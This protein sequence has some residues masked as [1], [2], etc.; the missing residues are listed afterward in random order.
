MGEVKIKKRADTKKKKKK[1]KKTLVLPAVVN[2]AK[3][4][5]SCSSNNIGMK[6]VQIQTPYV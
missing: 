1:K 3:Q 6:D 4:R 2:D 5:N